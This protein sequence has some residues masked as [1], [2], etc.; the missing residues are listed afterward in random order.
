MNLSC[1]ATSSTI[2]CTWSQPA[3][4]TLIN[5]LL[6]WRYTGPCDADT[7]SFLLSGQDRNHTLRDLEEGGLYMVMIYAVNSVG[8]GPTASVQVDTENSGA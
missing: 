3:T 1:S 2:T 7:Q 6:S 4:D 5:Y 8:R